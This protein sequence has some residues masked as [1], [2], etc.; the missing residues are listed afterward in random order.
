ML[1]FRDESDTAA[2][3]MRVCCTRNALTLLLCLALP[4]SAADF[5]DGFDTAQPSWQVIIPNS[6]DASLRVQRRNRFIRRSGQASENIEIDAFRDNPIV[7]LEH[8]LPKSAPI[9]D[10]DLKLQI[11]SSQAGAVVS[12]RIVFPK[13]TDPRNNRVLTALLRGESYLDPGDWQTLRVDVTESKFRARLARLRAE[14]KGTPLNLENAYFDRVI[15]EPRLRRGTTEFFFDDLRWTGYASPQRV[16]EQVGAE[17]RAPKR[18]VQMAHDRLL[19]EG[20]PSILTFAPY[21]GEPID[22]L[23]DIGLNV[24]W[25]DS[26]ENSQLIS[27]LRQNGLWAMATPPREDGDA[28]AAGRLRLQLDKMNSND[29][30]V[31][32]WYVGT[33]VPGSADEIVRNHTALIRSADKL[34]RP[35]F[36]DIASNRRSYSRMLD[37]VG[38]SRHPLHTEFTTLDYRHFL[39][40]KIRQLLPGTF[41]TTWIQTEIEPEDGVLRSP[42]PVIEPEQIRLLTW[43]ALAAGVRGIGYWKSTGFDSTF[44]G[45]R[46]R[47]LIIAITNQEIELLEPWLATQS[48]IE[49]RTV[50]VSG[51]ETS[52]RRRETDEDEPVF[53]LGAI[54]QRRLAKERAAEIRR[55]KT[56]KRSSGSIELAVIHG[57]N[58]QLLM[59]IWHDPETQFVPGQMA[60]RQ[61]EMIIPGIED[62]ATVWELSTTGVRTVRCTPTPSGKRIELDRFDQVAALVVSTDPN[63]GNILRSRI[64]MIKVRSAALWLE[65]AKARLERVRQVDRELQLLG[66]GQPDGLELLERATQF[67]EIA[68]RDYLRNVSSRPDSGQP[69]SRGYPQSGLDVASIRWNA[70]AALQSLR[71]LQRTHWREAVEGRGSPLA[72]PYTACFQTLPEH[73]RLVRRIGASPITAIDNRLPSGDF[74]GIVDAQQLVDADWHNIQPELNGVRAAIEVTSLPGRTNSFLRMLSLPT[75]SDRAPIVLPATPLALQTPAV[76]VEPGQIV[77]ISGRIRVPYPISSSLEG[78]TLEESLTGSRLRWTKTDD[79]QSFELI[80]EVKRDS[81]LRLRLTM[82]GLGEVWFDD[83]QIVVS[84]LAR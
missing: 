80:R 58:G 71:I 22:R 8:A 32:F 4:A 17:S 77:H 12:L 68:E 27:E 19:I 3:R 74:E 11:R 20:R 7:R 33:R 63:W 61:L 47:E 75:S 54:E 53:G 24:L 1:G 84:Q 26:Y 46:E 43:T 55:K 6:T 31:L 13:Q 44:P 72:S 69:L 76:R 66:V 41:V 18:R 64:N 16:I 34:Q 38:L 21:H 67:V 5:I 14:L 30:G 9:E 78:V 83:L 40:Q 73:W 45:A 48:V 79:W 65:L 60:T 25:V 57:P 51:V 81:D 50:P 70:E 28:A 62:T 49:Y 59:P 37:G 42:L 36:A 15:I 2:M 10:L 23:R 56:T 29:P 52:R 82:H 35:I 39:S